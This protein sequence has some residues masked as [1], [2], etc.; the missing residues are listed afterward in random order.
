MLNVVILAVGK[1][2]KEYFKEAAAEYKK[3]LGPYA[4]IVIEEV[5]AESF[6]R[7]SDKE[8][9]K[10][11]EGERLSKL[12]NKYSGSE[13]VVLDEKGKDFPSLIFVDFLKSRDRRIVF[14]IGGALGLDDKI[15]D[16]PYRK[17]SLS[18]MTLP[19]ELARVVLMEQL[20][21]A[22]TILQGKEYHY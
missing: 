7:D 6:K 5:E 20:Y 19:H 3:R 8:K 1:I 13:V 11:T 12:L 10:R 9:A 18:A 2:K 21:R 17:M 22:A 16:G 14:V 15:L 4:K